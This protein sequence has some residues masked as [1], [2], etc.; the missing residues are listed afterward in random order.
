MALNDMTVKTAVH[1]HGAFDI[2]F[3]AHLQQSEVRAVEGLLHGGDGVRW[4]MADV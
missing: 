4:L 2:D 3:V 1:Q